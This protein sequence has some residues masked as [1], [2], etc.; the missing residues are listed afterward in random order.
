VTSAVARQRSS[1]ELLTNWPC[2][3]DKTPTSGFGFAVTVAR[4]ELQPGHPDRNDAAR[5]AF[6]FQFQPKVIFP[7]PSMAPLQPSKPP[8]WM[9]LRPL[10]HCN[11]RSSACAK[12]RDANMETG[13]DGRTQLEFVVPA[14]VCRPS[15]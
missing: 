14:V 9:C 11:R 3:V 10:S 13:A 1:G 12:G 8:G 2:G 15:V 6:E 4:G 5:K 7:A